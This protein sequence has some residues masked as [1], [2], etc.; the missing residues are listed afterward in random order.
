M[1]ELPSLKDLELIHMDEHGTSLWPAILR[2]EEA[3]K[4]NATKAPKYNDNL[5]GA[6]VLGFFLRDFWLHQSHAFGII[7]YRRLTQEIASALAGA[8]EADNATISKLGLYYRNHLIRVFRSDGGPLPTASDHPSRPSLDRVRDQIVLDMAKTPKTKPDAKKQALVRDG[9]R[10]TVTGDYDFDSCKKHPELLAKAQATGQAMFATQVA[11]I[12]SE[13]AQD[14][15]KAPEYAGSALAILKMFGLGDVVESILGGNVNN[16]SNVFTLSAGLHY[17]YDHLEFWLEEIPGQPNT[18][19]ICASSDAF[20]GVR[21]VPPPQQH[22]KFQVAPEVV[23]ACEAKD[24]TVPALPSRSL[25]AIRAACSRVAHMSG[26][27]EQIDQILRD[28][29]DTAVMASDGSTADLLMSMMLQ[30]SNMVRVGA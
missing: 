28:L 16:H 19:K 9:Y 23:A 25:L 26:A 17:F 30:T 13:S 15:D 1:F 10:C 7:P 3:A 22:I 6:R 12:F 2:A 8:P 20:F 4:T 29:E 18:Y 24:I 11:H 14:G 21:G 27:A 5:I